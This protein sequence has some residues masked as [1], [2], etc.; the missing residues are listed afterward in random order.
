[1][2]AGPQ[3]SNEYSIETWI[4]PEN[5]DQNGPARIISYSSGTGS[6]NF[7]LGQKRVQYGLRN[8][9]M[10]NGIDNNGRPGLYTAMADANVKTELQHVVVTFDQ[11]NGRRIYVNG[12]FDGK[13]DPQGPGSL[14]NWNPNYPL[15]WVMNPLTIVCGKAR[16]IL[17]RFSPSL[18]PQQV[19]QT[20]IPIWDKH[21]YSNSMCQLG[22]AHRVAI[23]KWKVRE[24]DAFSYL[25][26]KPTFLARTPITSRSRTSVSP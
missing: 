19:A 16:C 23:L 13:V 9:S 8:R 6:R 3:G 2:I 14:A 25:L 22:S 17:P 15:S 10:A 26:A 18:T 1:M 20:S 12:V 24:F 21:I 4:V 7:T 11:V 5:L